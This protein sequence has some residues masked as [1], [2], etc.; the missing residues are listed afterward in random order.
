VTRPK[1]D[2]FHINAPSITGLSS[3]RRI[4]AIDNAG[5][6]AAWRVKFPPSGEAQSPATTYWDQMTFTL[7]RGLAAAWPILLASLLAA[8]TPA[9]LRTGAP[10]TWQASPNF[11]GRRPNYVVIHHTSNDSNDAALRTLTDPLRG[12]SAHYLVAR[13]GTVFQ[14][15]D[16]TMR[17]WHAGKSYWG[18]N[19]DLNSS[20][21]GI[22]LDNNGEEPFPAAQISALLA[23]LADVGER[24]RIPAANYIGHADVAPTRK[25]DP[26]RLFPWRTLAEHGFGLWCDAPT[27][28]PPPNFDAAM[29]LQAL[30][31]DVSDVAAAIQAFKLHFVQD[32]V[33][34][35]LHDADLGLLACL[36]QRKA[37]Q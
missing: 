13:D 5:V 11:D 36:V 32:D 33:S 37:K 3:L 16:E 8:C 18:G 27:S 9:P 34:P 29:A 35:V 12:V 4:R 30:G 26:S 24:Y 20:S 2:D 23:L 19:T 17:A 14:L 6:G 21:I 22:E 31:Y 1:Q 7:R 25:T 10:S 15:V 28:G